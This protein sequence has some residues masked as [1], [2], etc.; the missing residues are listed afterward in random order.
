MWRISVFLC[1][2]RGACVC[3]MLF[4][5]CRV[6]AISTDCSILRSW[7]GIS[8]YCHLYNVVAVTIYHQSCMCGL[9]LCCPFMILSIPRRNYEGAVPRCWTGQSGRCAVEPSPLTP[10]LLNCVV[11][12]ASSRLVCSF[13]RVGRA[14]CNTLRPL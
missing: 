13:A 8:L 5:F 14:D 3:F 9:L 10:G 2:M 4:V 6:P 12:C 11:S 1:N 7:S